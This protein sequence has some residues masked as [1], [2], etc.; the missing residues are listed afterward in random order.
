MR[1]GEEDCKVLLADKT[2][3][4][5]RGKK[6]GGKRRALQGMWRFKFPRR[7]ADGYAIECRMMRSV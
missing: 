4:E 7:E 3:G 5:R 6:L 1:D 2:P